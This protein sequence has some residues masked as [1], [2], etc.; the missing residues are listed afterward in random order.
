N[1]TL[2]SASGAGQT[3]KLI[4]QLFGAVLLQAGAEAVKRAE[5]GG[6]DPAAIPA[7][8]VGGRAD[9]RIMQEFMAKVAAREFSPT[10]RID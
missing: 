6:V 10:G 8:L 3:T 5:A 7:A 9:S 2:M 4:K 1:Y